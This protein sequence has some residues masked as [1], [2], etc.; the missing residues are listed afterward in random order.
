[1]STRAQEIHGFAHAAMSK[2][3]E[4]AHLRQFIDTL[5]L[6]SYLH[7]ILSPLFIEIESAILND[8]GFIDW[9]RIQDE[10]STARR[11]IQALYTEVAALK[12]KKDKAMKE[13]TQAEELRRN[14]VN[15]LESIL[16]TMK[17]S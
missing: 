16:K 3:E 1:M 14:S 11:T 4:I 5:P 6:N 13:A 8:L 17:R 12:D 9:Q 2:R 7:D 10:Q 15:M